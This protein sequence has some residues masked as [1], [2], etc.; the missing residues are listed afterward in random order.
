[1]NK[2]LMKND[3]KR[4]PMLLCGIVIL[5][6]GIQL[7]R[8]A[9]I[10]LSPWGVFHDGV[11]IVSD[12]TFGNVTTLFGFI[13][14]LL[15]MIFLK[16]KIGIGTIFNMAIIGNLINLY[17]Y[18]YPSIPDNMYLR[19]GIFI[20]GVLLTTFGRSLY[21]AS[22]LGQGPR[23]GLFVGLSRVTNIDVKY[24][25]PVIEGS[26]LIIGV[27]LGGNIGFGTILL[28]AVSSYLVQMFFKVLGFNSKKDTQSDIT[29]Y[30]LL[31]N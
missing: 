21:I 2:E 27:L 5:S 17:E 4:I 26:V 30:L 10:G 16:T 12:V 8:L 29:K 13:I 20:M 7:T 14:L 25:K 23:D 3:L 9:Y 11:S 24:V 15:S 22:D 28:W 18:I 31:E 6:I 1:M 19:V